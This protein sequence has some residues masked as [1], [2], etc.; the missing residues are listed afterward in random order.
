MKKLIIAALA[1]LPMFAMAETSLSMGLWDAV[2]DDEGNLNFSYN[3][4]DALLDVYATMSYRIVDADKGG[5]F[6]T[7][8]IAA[9][10]AK[11]VDIE[12]EFGVGKSLQISHDNGT[13]V[14]TRHHNFYETLPYMIVSASLKAHDGSVVATNNVKP[15]VT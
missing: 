7:R 1:F 2:Y 14:M 3:G 9:G 13:V 6:D 5:S 15:F 8:S 12:D 11:V 10:S 4:Q